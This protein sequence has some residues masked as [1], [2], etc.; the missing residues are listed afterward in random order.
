MFAV[1]RIQIREGVL[2]VAGLSETCGSIERGG[3]NYYQ[4]EML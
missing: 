3:E 2:K 1:L 4:N